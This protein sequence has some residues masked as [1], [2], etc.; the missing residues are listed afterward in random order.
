MKVFN[1][2]KGVYIASVIIAALLSFITYIQ[3]S[4]LF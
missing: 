3:N 1:W 2:H 4:F